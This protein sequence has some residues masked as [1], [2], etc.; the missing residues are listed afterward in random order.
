MA[1]PFWNRQEPCD[2]VALIC[3]DRARQ[4]TNMPIHFSDEELA[5]LQALAAPIDQRLRPTFLQEV[6]AALEAEAERTGVAPI[7]GVHRMGAW[8]KGASG[9][10]R[11]SA[12][13]ASARA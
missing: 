2:F 3:F 5:L 10:R 4:R 9:I 7:G 1:V 6:T 13:R 8:F 11:R 12:R